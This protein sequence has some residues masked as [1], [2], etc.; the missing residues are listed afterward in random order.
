MSKGN[1]RLLLQEL[2]RVEGIQHLRVVERLPRGARASPSERVKVGK[3][4]RYRTFVILLKKSTESLRCERFQ[5]R[6]A[7]ACRETS[8]FFLR[9]C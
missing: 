7:S 6:V 1:Q 8:F 5:A 9:D 3:I 4:R 2:R